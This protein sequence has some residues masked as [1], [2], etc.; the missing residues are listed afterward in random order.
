MFLKRKYLVVLGLV[1]IFSSCSSSDFT[2]PNDSRYDD[3]DDIVNVPSDV[4]LSVDATDVVNINSEIF[5]VNNDWRQIPNSTF[6][7]FANTLDNI[8][9]QL[10]RYPGGWESEFY[11]WQSNSTPGW[12]NTPSTPGASV[13]TLKNNTNNYSIVIPTT[14]AMDRSVGSEQW[15]VAI[16]ALKALANEAIVSSNISDGI[17]E[18]GNEWWLQYAGGSDREEK[19]TKYVNIAMELAEYIEDEFPGH[20]FKLLINGDYTHP[21]EFTTMK[22]L[23]IRAYDAIDGVALHTYVGYDSDTHNMADLEQRITDCANNFN[24]NNNYI[25][26]SEWMPSRLYNDYALYMEA[27]NII[28][29]IIHIYARAG[30][31]AGAYWPPINSSVPGLGITNWNYSKIFPVGQIFGE[32]SDSYRGKAL[33]TTSDRFHLA[34]ALQDDETMVL[35]VTGGNQN[36]AKVGISVQGF[37]IDSIE[38]V[39]RFVPADYSETNLAEPYLTETSEATLNSNNE[40]VIEVNK[41]GKFQIYKIILTGN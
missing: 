34:A 41:E 7:N 15:N 17:V 31:N 28:P 36:S 26:L 4:S 9:Y 10:V 16:E 30:A 2:D 20:T 32:L 19:L 8:N 35:F 6:P 24:P 27:A 25:Y 40:V 3:L 14:K 39:T 37:D 12:D 29:D 1:V 11:D 23:F 38:S 18:I 33:K 5:G 21:E 13:E 22:S